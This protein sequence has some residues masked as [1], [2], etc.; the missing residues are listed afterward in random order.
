MKAI[1]VRAKQ[2]VWESV[3]DEIPERGEVRIAVRATAVNRADLSQRAGKYPPPPGSSSILGLE[4]AG[5]VDQVGEGVKSFE[6]GERVCALL[7]GG[8]Y[9]EQVIVPAGQVVR[10]PKNLDFHEAAAIPEVFA[11]AYLNLYVE[12]RLQPGENVLIHAG[13]SGVGTAAVQLCHEFQNP[14]FVTAGSAT[15][16]ERC[17]QLGASQG[18]NRNESSFANDVL[19]WTSGEGV[20]VVLD[21]VG[22]DYFASNLSVLKTGGRLV[23]IGLLSGSGAQIPLGRL[24]VKRISVIGSTLRARSIAAK[25]RI[26]D[27]LERRVFPLIESGQIRPV[28]DRIL[29]L[30]NANEAHELVAS[31]TTFGKVVLDVAS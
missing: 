31:N 16:I 12:A 30:E 19:N 9:A 1:V 7:A 11:T 15:K 28:I 26:M 17:L 3:P 27:E 4:C 29:P 8:G 2:L 21:P 24:L 25:A 14:C 6:P 13:G 18:C 5:V 10:I 23:V 20:D 22:A